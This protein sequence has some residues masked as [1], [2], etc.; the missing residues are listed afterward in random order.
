M[1]SLMGLVLAV[2]VVIAAG[3]FV[4]WFQSRTGYPRRGVRTGSKSV[5]RGGRRALTRREGAWP[6][7]EGTGSVR[8]AAATTRRRPDVRDVLEQ[9]RAEKAS[10]A[11]PQMPGR[12]DTPETAPADSSAIEHRSLRA[13]NLRATINT[14]Y[15]QSGRSASPV[16]TLGEL[17]DGLNYGAIRVRI[18]ETRTLLKAKA[19]DIGAEDG[20]S[21][22][23]SGGRCSVDPARLEA[24]M[25][26]RIDKMLVEGAC[27]RM[28]SRSRRVSRPSQPAS[29]TRRRAVRI[30][31]P[32]GVSRSG[33]R[34]VRRRGD[35][36]LRGLCE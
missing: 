20:A 2:C 28:P 10:P 14:P 5:A 4:V 13:E 18:E 23:S 9:W 30:S 16:L 34:V 32:A 1:T 8:P 6:E 24:A 29:Q 35:S 27:P 11:I 3:A 33:R 22:G 12:V 36:R 7:S 25:A 19:L 31:T 15:P 21:E 26:A 17:E